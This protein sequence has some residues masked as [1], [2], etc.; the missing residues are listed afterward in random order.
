MAAFAVE[1]INRRSPAFKLLLTAPE[2]T[3]ISFWYIPPSLQDLDPQS[4]EYKQRLHKV[5][6]EIKKKMMESGSMMV[7]YQPLK[8]HP[9]FF[10]LVVQSS[11]VSEQD[12]IYFL[13]TIE[14]YGKEL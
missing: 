9:N 12:I 6:P 4:E 10:R 13:D 5:A 11:E 1:E 3:N 2:C 14:S 7:T 8:E